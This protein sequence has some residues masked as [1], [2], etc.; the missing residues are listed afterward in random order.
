M[1]P[2]GINDFPMT[3][4]THIKVCVD[5]NLQYS[6]Q[7]FDQKKWIRYFYLPAKVTLPFALNYM[8]IRKD[9]QFWQNTKDLCSY[10]Q[11][12]NKVPQAFYNMKVVKMTLVLTQHILQLD[13]LLG[14]Y[15]KISLHSIFRRIFVNIIII[16]LIGNNFIDD[17][18]YKKGERNSILI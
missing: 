18:C 8:L 5:F 11:R 7:Q 15:I 13:H 2:S 16:I 1:C 17:K 4:I 6:H 12:F 3:N 9:C 10:I 14:K